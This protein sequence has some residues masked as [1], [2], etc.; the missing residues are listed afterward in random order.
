MEQK[1]SAKGISAYLYKKFTHHDIQWMVGFLE[2]RSIFCDTT[3]L[4][5][6]FIKPRLMSLFLLVILGF[7]ILIT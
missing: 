1:I 4:L 7:T 5:L 2:R 6:Y 3:I